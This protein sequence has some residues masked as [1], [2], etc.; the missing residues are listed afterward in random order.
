MLMD[1]DP[2]G[3]LD[4]FDAICRKVAEHKRGLSMLDLG[5]AH[6]AARELYAPEPDRAR[7]EELAAALGLCVAEL[8]AAS[9]TDPKKGVTA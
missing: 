6:A 4:A 7:L 5:A 3:T 1:L 2:A 9:G 8:E